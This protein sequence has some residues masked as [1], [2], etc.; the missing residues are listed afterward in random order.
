MPALA[1]AAFGAVSDRYGP[2]RVS[3]LGFVIA[4]ISLALLALIRDDSIVAKA[5]LTV[6]LFTLGSL[7]RNPLPLLRRR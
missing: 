7:L 3:L 6:L 1:G 5:G 4:S 2:K